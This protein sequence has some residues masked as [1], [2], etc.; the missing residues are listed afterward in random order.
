MG[1][2]RIKDPQAEASYSQKAAIGV[3]LV[4]KAFPELT[5]GEASQILDRLK[6]EE[7]GTREGAIAGV[8]D[9]LTMN[10]TEA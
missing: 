1:N 2:Y 5:K 8:I 7:P 9:L 6:S 4:E 3:P 10:L